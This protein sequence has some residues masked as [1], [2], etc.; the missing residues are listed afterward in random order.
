MTQ[1]LTVD[2]ATDD[3]AHGILSQVIA[4]LPVSLRPSTTGADLVAVAGDKWLRTAA[5]AAANGAKG[6]MVIAPG[7]DW[8]AAAIEKI[9]RANLPLVVDTTWA[10]NPAVAEAAPHL[11]ALDG[12]DAS[13]Q[14]LVEAPL[15]SDLH[16]VAIAQLGLVRAGLGNL[17]EF[18][19]DRWDKHGYEATGRLESGSEIALSA[20]LTDARRPNA[21]LRLLTRRAAVRVSLPEPGTATYGTA[22]VSDETGAMLL[23]TSYESAHRAAWR[24]LHRRVT[25][26]SASSDLD[27]LLADIELLTTAR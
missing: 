4:S 16:Q 8:D 25:S 5:Q 19:I 23:P 18:R 22:T 26:G 27:A 13:I 14:T 20:T 10:Y 11:T 1:Q 7:P 24:D 6:L 15:G 2:S 12:Q 9:R 21:T 3:N 17:S